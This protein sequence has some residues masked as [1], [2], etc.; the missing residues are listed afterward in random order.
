MVEAMRE[1]TRAV[2]ATLS[3]P[4]CDSPGLIISGLPPRSAIPA[5]KETRV[6]VDVL[7]KIT[8]TVWGPA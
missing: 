1:K 4:S 6:R 7:S 8:A 3:L 2:S 5:E